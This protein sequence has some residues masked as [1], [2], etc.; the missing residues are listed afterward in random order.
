VLLSLRL[1]FLLV[2]VAFPLIEIAVLIKAGEMIGF[3]P[4]ISLLVASAALGAL[5]IRHQGLTMVNRMLAAASEGKLPFAPMLDSY[6]LIVA[7]ALLIV[8]GLVSDVIGLLLLVPPLRALAIRSALSGL[9]GGAAGYRSSGTRKPAGPTV[10][11]ATYERIDE[12]D[13]DHKTG[14]SGPS[15]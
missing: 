5:V 13:D 4:T 1:A 10:I 15:D 2:F 3:W 14:R 6:A 12:D 7:G 9:A 8:P 11:N